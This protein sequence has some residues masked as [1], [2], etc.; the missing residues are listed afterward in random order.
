MKFIIF[1]PII[2]KKT[3]LKFNKLNYI[4]KINIYFIYLFINV[5]VWISLHVSQLIPRILKLTII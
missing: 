1:Q 5:G 4:I 3:N 2:F